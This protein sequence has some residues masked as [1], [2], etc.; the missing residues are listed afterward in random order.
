MQIFTNTHYDFLKW[1]FHALAF[2]AL[3][4]LIGGFLFW[5]NGVNLGI[6]FAGGADITL[7]FQDRVPIDEL[8]NTVAD[9]TIQQYGKP[10]DNSVLIRLPKQ[11]TEG[12]YAGAVVTALYKKLNPDPGSRLDL[13]FKGR[14]AIAEL[15][16]STDPDRKGS[17]GHDF[18]YDLASRIIEKRSEL[19]IFRTIDEVKSV[20]GTT[21]ATDLVLEQNSILGKFLV[22]SQETVGPQVGAELQRK[23]ILAIL[24]ATLAMGLYIGIRF[25]LK[26]GFAAVLCLVHD[27]LIALAF[28]AMIRGEFEIITVA[29]FLMIIGY[30]INDTV[31]VYDRVRENVK[32]QRSREDFEAIL[33]RSLNQTLSRTILTGGTVI[34]VLIS[35]ILFGGE[36]IHEFSW[37]LLIGILA[38]TYSTLFVVPAI[39]IAW[40]RRIG[41]KS[42]YGSSRRTEPS[43][44]EAPADSKPAPRAAKQRAS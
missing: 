4:I 31:V 30:S 13:N 7:K 44:P 14:D 16:K 6:D 22:L 18:Y 43:R 40:N 12:D 42:G 17:A 36:V 5:R 24:L 3:F 25:D 38:G 1:R 9:S 28:F 33:N 32:K 11:T 37:L 41:S 20:E 34:L 15:L 21:P 35:L 19:G 10:E 8:R 39:V 29:A 27:V 23:A 2:S 26:F